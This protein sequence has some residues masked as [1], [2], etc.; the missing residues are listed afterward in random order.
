MVI[1]LSYILVQLYKVFR[2]IF[3]KRIDGLL[4]IQAMIQ[5]II[6]R[7]TPPPVKHISIKIT[8]VMGSPTIIVE[9][10]TNCMDIHIIWIPHRVTSTPKFLEPIKR[11]PY[12]AYINYMV[13]ESI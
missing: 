2:R 12:D 8:Q 13:F 1:F 3:K 5:N 9:R 6:K 10:S 7:A 11:R 4:F